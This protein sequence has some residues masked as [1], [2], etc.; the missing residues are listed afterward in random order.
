MNTNGLK[1]FACR[2][3]VSIYPRIRIDKRKANPMESRHERTLIGFFEEI[4]R[5]LAQVYLIKVH[6]NSTI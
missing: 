3:I 4:H 2:E 1:F 5:P 6:H